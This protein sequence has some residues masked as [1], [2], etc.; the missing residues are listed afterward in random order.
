[1]MAIRNNLAVLLADR[2]LKIT[3]VSLETGIS[4][5]TLTSVYYNRNKMIQLY[6]LDTLCQ[7]LGITPG[8]F[9]AYDPHPSDEHW[10]YDSWRGNHGD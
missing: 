10:Y 1:M 7:Y 6:T 2:R 8:E 5:N 4:R 9:F 3:Q